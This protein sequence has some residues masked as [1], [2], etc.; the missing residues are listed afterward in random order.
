MCCCSPA[1]AF[2]P[3]QPMEMP[4]VFDTC[5]Y[6]ND[7]SSKD[8]F[9]AS[10]PCHCY[11]KNNRHGFIMSHPPNSSKAKVKKIQRASGFTSRNEIM[12]SEVCVV[13]HILPIRGFMQFDLLGS[14]V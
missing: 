8:P 12:T 14:P 9:H 5:F 13:Q 11:E 4:G 6:P 3:F 7:P 1:C 10:D 2:R